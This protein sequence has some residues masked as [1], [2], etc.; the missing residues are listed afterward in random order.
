[1]AL[2]QMAHHFTGKF[3]QSCNQMRIFAQTIA[4][5]QKTVSAYLGDGCKA[6]SKWKVR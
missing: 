2:P 3:Q 6:D 4:L 1:M 5:W